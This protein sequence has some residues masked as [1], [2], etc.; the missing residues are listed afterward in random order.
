MTTEKADLSGIQTQYTA[1]IYGTGTPYGSSPVV[2]RNDMVSA[3]V[4]G[5]SS[6]GQLTSLVY[7]VSRLQPA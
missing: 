2:Y 6:S 4:S 3:V 7:D 5:L 1:Y